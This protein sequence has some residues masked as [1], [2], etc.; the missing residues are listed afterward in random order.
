MQNSSADLELFPLSWLSQYGYCPRRCGL[1]SIE[2]QWAENEYTAAGRTQHQRVHTPRMERRGDSLFFYEMD[3]FS[4]ALGVSGKSDCVEARS[5]EDGV[6]LPYAPGKFRLYPVEYKH[7]VVRQEEEYQIQLCAQAICL[8]EQYGCQIPEAAI[9][10]IDAHRRDAVTLDAALREK[11]RQAALAVQ[12]MLSGQQLPPAKYSAKCRKCSLLELC[13]P[14]LKRR[15]EGY[16]A[17]L[18]ELLQTEE[19]E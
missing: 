1:L 8:E 4:R 13:Q 2:Q 11:T 12:A 6:P 10:Y 18:W 9:F 14:K 5:C 16:C 17:S 7:G 19:P 3:L 15:A